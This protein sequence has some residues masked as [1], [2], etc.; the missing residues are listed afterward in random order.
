VTFDVGLGDVHYPTQT[1]AWADYDNDGDL[2]LFI[3][4]E[5]YPSQL[6]RNDGGRFTDVAGQAGVQNLQVAKG[7]SWGDYNRDRFPDLYVSNLAGDNRLYRNNR[8]GTFTDVATDLGVAGP[9]LS[10]PT[11]FWDY[12]NDGLLDLYVASYEVGVRFVAADYLGQ[13]VTC[14]PDRLYRGTTDGR[15]EDVATEA[16]LTRPTQPMGSNFGDFNND[17]WLDFYLGTGYVDYDG[18]MP[19]LL[20]VNRGGRRFEDV[21]FAAG[22]GHL[23]KGH[24]VAFADLD[25]DG[26]QDIFE[27]MGGALAGDRFHNVLY[28][29]PGADGHWINVRLVGR[30]SNRSAIGA[31]IH[32][33]VGQGDA[34]RDIYRWVNSGGS[35]GANPLRQH[36]GLGN[37]SQIETLEVYWPT[38]DERQEWHD[39]AA[40]RWIEITESEPGYRKIPLQRL[41][42]LPVAGSEG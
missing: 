27:Q 29:N 33:V 40:D 32:V 10:F 24:G 13:S 5:R 34:R 7:C 30:R 23:Q 37:A 15:F 3:G 16:G 25:N 8:N 26:D 31:R 39:L 1:A 11:W 9:Y 14:E 38:S 28:H 2:D 4:N 36:I 22:V 42:F 6:F 20:F 21:T 17:G 12:D 18:L 19:N 35:F 41:D